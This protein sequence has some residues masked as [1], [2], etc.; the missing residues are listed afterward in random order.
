MLLAHNCDTSSPLPE[1]LL[2]ALQP[3]FGT[4]SVLRTDHPAPQS[5]AAAELTAPAEEWRSVFGTAAERLLARMISERA[6]D[7]I[8]HS[9]AISAIL[10]DPLIAPVRIM[11]DIIGKTVQSGSLISIGFPGPEVQFPFVK[12]DEGF[13]AW[14]FASFVTQAKYISTVVADI[15]NSEYE[16]SGR[17]QLTITPDGGFLLA[18]MDKYQEK[19]HQLKI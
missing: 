8:D 14:A 5:A 10:D 18:W 3:V 1:L 19:I 7:L 2:H 12:A 11:T 15:T 13:V 4:L 17:I 9:R 6:T 16:P